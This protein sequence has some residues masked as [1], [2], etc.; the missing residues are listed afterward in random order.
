MVIVVDFLTHNPNNTDVDLRI[1]GVQ[2]HTKGMGINVI[3]G[4]AFLSQ[5]VG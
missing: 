4:M 1:K 3:T 2:T 5:Q